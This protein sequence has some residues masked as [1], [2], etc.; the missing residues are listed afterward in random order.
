M[1]RITV[2]TICFNNLQDLVKTCQSVDG[3]S[4]PP[5]E[6][7]IIDGSSTKDIAYWLQNTEQPGFR[8]WICEPD[9]G[10]A[11]AFN[12]G[13]ARVTGDVIQLLNSGDI[14]ANEKVL[15][16]VGNAFE[17]DQSLKW[18]T[19]MICLIRMGVPVVVGKPFDPGKLYRG[20]RSVSHPT[21]FVKKSVYDQ[22]GLYSESYA[23]AMDYEMMCRLKKFKSGFLPIPFVVF[24]DTGVSTKNYFAAL[25]ETK[26]AY[27][28]NFGFSLPMELWQLRLKL[29]YTLQHTALGKFLFHVK[30]AL[31]LENM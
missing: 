30:R 4:S 10:I 19:G 3:Q 28:S 21:W 1:S 5:F 16:Q 23:I 13:I 7:W 8:K 29:L 31:G 12:K 25:A 6:H 20:M 11:D 27:Q 17:E 18:L 14:Y 26:K 9:K 22:V 15:E 2:I 24:D